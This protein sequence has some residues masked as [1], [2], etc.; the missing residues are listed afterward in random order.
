M[1]FKQQSTEVSFLKFVIDIDINHVI[2]STYQ[3]GWYEVKNWG[4]INLLH[5]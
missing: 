4:S 5:G 3:I 2:L 1:N